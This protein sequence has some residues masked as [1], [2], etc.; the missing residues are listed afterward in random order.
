MALIICKHVDQEISK[1]TQEKT[2]MS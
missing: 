2:I 1:E